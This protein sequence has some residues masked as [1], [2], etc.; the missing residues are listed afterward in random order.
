MRKSLAEWSQ[1][2]FKETL[3]GIPTHVCSAVRHPSHCIIG[4]GSGRQHFQF[5]LNK[6]L[7]LINEKG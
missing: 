6:Q 7:L 5:F 2:K 1:E 4:F 3:D